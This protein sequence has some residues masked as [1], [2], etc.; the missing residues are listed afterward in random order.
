MGEPDGRVGLVPVLA[1]RAGGTERVNADV[2]LVEANLRA[3]VLK[4]RDDHK[5]RMTA[6]AFLVRGDALNSVGASEALQLPCDGRV[7]D[8]VR[9]SR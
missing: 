6:A 3:G 5:G 8:G 7:K 1:A 4:D 2:T 9:R